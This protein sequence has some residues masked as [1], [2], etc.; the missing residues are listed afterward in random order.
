MDPEKILFVLRLPARLTVL[1]AAML[2][3]FPPAA[4][5]Y[6]VEIGLLETIGPSDGVQLYFDSQYVDSLR[7]DPVWIRIATAAWRAHIDEKNAKQ[8]AKKAGRQ[9]GKKRERADSAKPN[10]S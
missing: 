2:L 10:Q 1:L 3:N 4:I 8:N 7:Y 6:L 9:R 5:Y